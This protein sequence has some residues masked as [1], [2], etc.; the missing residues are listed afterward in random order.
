MIT[1]PGICVGTPQKG[2]CATQTP[3]GIGT[4]AEAKKEDAIAR[5][6]HSD[7]RRITVDNIAGE[8]ETGGLTDDVVDAAVQ[9]EKE[10]LAGRA[11][12][13]SYSR[14]HALLREASVA[15]LSP[16]NQQMSPRLI[17]LQAD[18]WSYKTSSRR[19]ISSHSMALTPS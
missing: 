5:L 13:L 3:D 12:L 10:V 19:N 14:K 17:S 16:V 6:P 18:V 4:P 8:A 11:V 2:Q 7:D 15:L 9:S 1:G